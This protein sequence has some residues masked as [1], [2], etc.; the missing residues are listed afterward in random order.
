MAKRREFNV[1]SLSFLDIMSCGFGAVIL[2]FIIINHATETTSQEINLQLLAEIRKIEENIRDET[3]NLIELRNTVDE[4]DDEIITTEGLIARIVEAIRELQA[5]IQETSED[6][7]TQQDSIEK[8]KAELKRLET[9]AANL[10]GS[11]GADETAGT[12]LRSFVGEGNRQYLTGMN[13]GGEHIV[14]LV[15]TS[16]SMLDETI[17]NIIRRRNFAKEQKLDSPKWQRAIRTVEWIVA[18][19]PKDRSFQLYTF[20]TG[21]TSATPD[22]ASEW[23]NTLDSE[24]VEGVIEHLKQLEP[25][26]G[27]SLHAAFSKLSSLDP[28]PDNVFLIVDGLPTLGDKEPKGSVVNSRERINLFTDSLKAIPVNTTINVILFPMEGDPMAAPSFWRLAQITGG[29]FLSP[30]DDWP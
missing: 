7:A 14:I 4:T 2:I 19:L 25:G 8:L 21:I 23:L 22:L 24:A 3:E 29:S 16:A 28:Q 5:Q 13:I 26:G 17:V 30:P 12:S 9:E 27:T 15:D 6:G 10:A 18:N 20:N 1:F 11:V